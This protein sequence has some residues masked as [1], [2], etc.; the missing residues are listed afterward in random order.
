M[1]RALLNE[2]PK[3]TFVLM[4]SNMMSQLGS[5]SFIKALLREQKK[6]YPMVLIIEDADEAIA[7]RDR[8][9]LSAIRPC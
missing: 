8:A 9:N 3:A 7:S 5:P 4:P 1:V 2:A 6:G